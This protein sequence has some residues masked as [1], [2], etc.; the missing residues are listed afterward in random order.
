[1]FVQRLAKGISILAVIGLGMLGV[2]VRY[3]SL[4]TLVVVMVMAICSIYAG[5]IFSQKSEALERGSR[6]S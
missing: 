6:A 1:M 2:A 4:I 5:R 3:L